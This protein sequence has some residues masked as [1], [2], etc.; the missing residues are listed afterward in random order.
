M[1][2][3]RLAHNPHRLGSSIAVLFTVWFTMTAEQLTT[4][5]I[6]L[7]K[8]PPTEQQL[9]AVPGISIGSRGGQPLRSGYPLP[10]KIELTSI[11]PRPIGPGDKFTVEVRLR[12]TGTSTFFLPTSQNGVEVLQHEG[13]GRRRLDWTL[14]FENPK[15]GRRVSSFVAV[16][17]GSAT[18]K[19]SLFPIAPGKEVRVLFRGD[20]TPIAAW[21]GDNLDQIQI[22]AGASEKTF[23]DHSYSLARESEEAVSVNA[24]TVVLRH[25]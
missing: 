16:A 2:L 5:V 25:P 19:D 23:E 3:M 18:V 9:T 24:E 15:T 12:N 14:I 21:F 22:R 17:M 10:L 13:K 1:H 7:T 11:D 20:L 8:P 6:D 4:P